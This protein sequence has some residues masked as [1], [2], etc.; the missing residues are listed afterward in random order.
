MVGRLCHLGGHSV[1]HFLGPFFSR[2]NLFPQASVLFLPEEMLSR[3]AFS[4][5]LLLL[6]TL[7]LSSAATDQGLLLLRLCNMVAAD[8]HSSSNFSQDIRRV[9]RPRA[10]PSSCGFLL[11]RGAFANEEVVGL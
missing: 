1:L 2:K 6:Q 10:S 8:A 9:A 11:V 4:G 5:A 3:C 7:A